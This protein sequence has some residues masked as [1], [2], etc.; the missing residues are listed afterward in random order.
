MK[1]I[2]HFPHA[3]REI[4][5]EWIP[6][7]DGTRLAARIWLPVDA[8]SHPVPAVLEYLPYRRRD[9]T[10][11]RDSVTQPY[12][13]GH[14]YAAVRVDIRGTGDSEG[15]LLDEYDLP[16]QHDG[17]E[18]IA[19]LARQ[20]WWAADLR[21]EE[22]PGRHSIAHVRLSLPIPSSLLCRE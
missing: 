2:R 17:V 3:I 1:T 19:W 20:S 9:G 8:E 4:M 11:D 13:A 14:G 16:E 7:P 5:T 10:S 12:L 21:P 15:L 18:V 6:M 22:S